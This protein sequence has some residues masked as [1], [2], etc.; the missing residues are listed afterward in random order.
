MFPYVGVRV[1]NDVLDLVDPWFGF[2]IF[3]YRHGIIRI[4]LEVNMFGRELMKCGTD[5][6]DVGWNPA[7]NS[8]AGGRISEG[9]GTGGEDADAP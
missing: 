9:E 3:R 5:S 1:A 8:E 7:S 6:A 2:P 4:V